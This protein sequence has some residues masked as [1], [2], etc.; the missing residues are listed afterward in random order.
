[1][2]A[3]IDWVFFERNGGI[4]H[5]DDSD[6][7]CNICH[8]WLGHYHSVNGQPGSLEQACSDRERWF[9][10]QVL[11]SLDGDDGYD[12]LSAKSRE[13]KDL[14]EENFLM[15]FQN[16]IVCKDLDEAQKTLEAERDKLEK[17]RDELEKT[18]CELEAARRELDN[19]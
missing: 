9:R 17:T 10:D 2:Q 3:P 14:Q 12:E 6:P 8:Q 15:R 11:T 1:M 4:Y 18:L 19:A 13:V 7:S 16:D 5:D